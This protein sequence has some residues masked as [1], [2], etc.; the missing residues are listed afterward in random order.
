MKK[1]I[2]EKNIAKEINRVQAAGLLKMHINAFS[3][4]KKRYMEHGISA[5]YPKKPGP[6]KGAAYN[7][8]PEWI[9]NI[10]VKV[11]ESRMDLGP[12]PL[13]DEIY[14]NYGVKLDSTTIWRILKRKKVRYGSEYKRWTQEEPKLYCLD[15]PGLELQMDGSYPFGRSRKI[16][17]FDAID[18]CSRYVCAKLYNRETAENAIEFVKYMVS[19]APFRIQRIRVDNRY[20]KKFREYCESIGIEVIE[21]DPYT[22]K[23]NGKIERFHKTMKR[24]FYW[25]YCSFHDSDEMLQYKLNQWLHHYNTDRKHGGYGMDRMTPKQKIAST[26]FLSLGNINYPQNVTLT[27]QQYIS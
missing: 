13:V 6:K 20:G 11:A 2:L 4:L 1:S 25:K 14:E 12:V 18:D 5:L 24:E 21:N 15:L 22:P 23:Q 7:K 17:S 19:K 10:V 8:T 3:R 16:V 26:L 9:E 27:L